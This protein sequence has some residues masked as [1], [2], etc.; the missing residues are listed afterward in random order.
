M[1]STA[2]AAWQKAP[3]KVVSFDLD[4]TLWPIAEVIQNAEAAHD[5]W[6]RE[7]FPDCW[8]AET[9]NWMMTCRQRL[10][11][12]EGGHCL[13]FVRKQTL[14]AYFRYVGFS[15]SVA[16]ANAEQA[17]EVFRVYRNRVQPLAGV[18]ALL[19]QLRSCSKVASLTNGNV[20]LDQTSLKGHFHLEL[21]PERAGTRKPHADMFYAVSDH[22]D[23]KPETVLH[24]GDHY[25][26][27]VQG[28]L[29]A[30]MNALWLVHDHHVLGRVGEH[31]AQMTRW[32]E[33]HNREPVAP[34]VTTISELR[35]FLFSAVNFASSVSS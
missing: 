18:R 2:V 20:D 30:G 10:I 5:L 26:D 16:Q 22:F 32:T 27:D 6:L 31:K 1:K 25:E 13:T 35:A 8:N 33:A 17:F 4:D 19:N 9:S 11:E 14:E 7:T 28:A 3:I 21:N 23:V 12:E 29:R 24:I 15:A 34:C